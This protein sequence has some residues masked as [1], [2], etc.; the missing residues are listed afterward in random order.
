VKSSVCSVSGAAR[1]PAATAVDLDDIQRKLAEIDENL[2]RNDLS[3][4][5]R[6]EHLAERKRLYLLKHPETRRGTAGGKARQG[7]ASDTVSLAED[8]ATK[9]GRTERAAR[10]EVQIAES[11]PEALCCF[12]DNKYADVV[13]IRGRWRWRVG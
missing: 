9:T 12:R 1:P 4:L 11:I 10:Q 6:S 13:L 2:I 8:V 5:Q 7:A 3:T